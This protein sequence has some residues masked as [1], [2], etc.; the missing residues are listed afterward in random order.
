MSSDAPA[1]R[2]ARRRDRL[3][4]ATLRSV[5]ALVV[6]IV[7]G[8]LSGQLWAGVVRLPTYTIGKDGSARTS[9]RG[10]AEYFN[11]DAWYI[12]IGTIAGLLLGWLVWRLLRRWGWPVAVVA[13][14]C[15]LVGAGVAL[16]TGLSIGPGSFTDRLAAGKPGDVIEVA[17]ELRAR[18]AVLVWVMAAITPTLLLASLGPEDPDEP[19]LGDE[20][21]RRPQLTG[22]SPGEGGEA[23]PRG[24]AEVIWR[25]PDLQPT[26]SSRDEHDLQPPG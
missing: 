19:L 2:V 20:L 15:G 25:D 9:E 22:S 26:A 23:G 18:S 4:V 1:A 8:W 13:A 11:A 24:G 14:L 5:V 6:A 10:L 17:L 16:W 21:V 3:R 12:L 7:L